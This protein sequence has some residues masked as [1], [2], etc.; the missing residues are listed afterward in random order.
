MKKMS[1]KTR[2]IVMIRAEGLCEGCRMKPIQ[3][4][5]HRRF[6]SR[7][8]KHNIANLLALCGY[9]NHNNGSCHG[10]A[11][12]EPLEGWAISAFDKRAESEIPFIDLYGRKWF[13]DDE[14]GK[15]RA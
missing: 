3:N 11:H 14:G 15:H 10:K 5:H 13:L 9:G 2:E 1:E 7:G 12:N 8:G 6:K 4:V